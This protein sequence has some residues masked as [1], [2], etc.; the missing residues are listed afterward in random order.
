MELVAAVSRWLADDHAPALGDA[1]RFQAR[2]AAQALEIAARELALATEHA[3]ADLASLGTL[4][5]DPP[6]D[7][8]AIRGRLAAGIRAGAY[9]DDLLAV[10]QVLRGHVR[11]KL[12]VA[13]PGYD[14]S[15]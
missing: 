7:A 14:E 15:S 2:L 8:V 5:K 13:R 3:G 6:D 11:R 1:Q 4:L 10:A 9:D 12:A